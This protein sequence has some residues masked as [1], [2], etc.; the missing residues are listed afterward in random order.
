[1]FLVARML[2]GGCLG[3]VVSSVDFKG[4]FWVEFKFSSESSMCVT[5]LITTENNHIYSIDINEGRQLPRDKG[6]KQT[7]HIRILCHDRVK[8]LNPHCVE[9]N[10]YVFRYYPQNIQLK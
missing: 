5:M 3:S 1:M 10:Y 7:V 9:L 2:P 6:S 8:L 4:R